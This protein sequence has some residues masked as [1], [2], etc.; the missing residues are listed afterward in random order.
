MV[1]L[2]LDKSGLVLL[3]DISPSDKIWDNYKV[4]SRDLSGLYARTEFEKYSKRIWDCARSLKFALKT[5][6]QGTIK[7]KLESARFCRV[8]WCPVCFWRRGLMWKGRFIKALPPLLEAHPKTRFVF[9]TLTVRNCQLE[10]LR[11]TLAAMNKAW[12]LLTKRKQFPALGWLKTVEVTRGKDGT[13]HPHFHILLMVKSSYFKM[14]YISQ[15]K[16]SELWK[17]CLDI[18]YN[19][20]VNVKAVKNRSARNIEGTRVN[21]DLMGAILETVKYCVKYEDLVADPVW[22]EGLTKQMH[23]LRSISLGGVFREYFLDDE[24]GEGEDLINNGIDDD[25]DLT[26]EDIS[27]IFDWGELI[28]KYRQ[29]VI[30]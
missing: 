28:R 27:L 6:P 16:W 1:D 4:R 18:N 14:G 26:D 15:A 13:A 10:D 5:D 2:S 9:L 8:R 21:D 23:K 22:L 7:L 29:R 19:P 20:I 3:A 11:D 25:Q 17:D 24:Q 12:V 30:E